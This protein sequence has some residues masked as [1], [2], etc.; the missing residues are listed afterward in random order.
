VRDAVLPGERQ[1]DAQRLGQCGI[2]DAPVAAQHTA[3]GKT[4]DRRIAIQGGAEAEE[5][6]YPAKPARRLAAA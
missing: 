1:R 5:A 3:I 4:N 6:V 2:D